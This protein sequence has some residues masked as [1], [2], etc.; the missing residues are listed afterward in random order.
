MRYSKN[1]RRPTPL[2]REVPPWELPG[3]FRLDCEPHH[4]PLMRW[5]ANVALLCIGCAFGLPMIVPMFWLCK[6]SR[7]ALQLSPF[8]AALG[9]LFGVV[10][11]LQS[12]RELAQIC[13]G[14]IDPSGEW[15]ARFARDRGRDT[16]LL[17]LLFLLFYAI[18]LVPW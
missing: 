4:G 3:N 1:T 15:D 14:R 18:L 11:W 13:A 8:L 12:R 7:F 16:F 9:G 10:A 2:K 6:A 17:S 5:F